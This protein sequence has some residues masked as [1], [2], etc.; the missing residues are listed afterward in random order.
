VG[1]RRGGTGICAVKLR[2][3]VTNRLLARYV[4]V[5]RLAEDQRGYVASILSRRARLL[6]LM[7]VLDNSAL[8]VLYAQCAGCVGAL[9]QTGAGGCL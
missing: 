4:V 8:R 7:W 6:G 2:I 3:D 5:I 9:R 1:S